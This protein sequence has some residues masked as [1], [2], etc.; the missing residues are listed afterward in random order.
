MVLTNH[1]PYDSDSLDDER[2]PWEMIGCDETETMPLATS[3]IPT[4]VPDAD[5]DAGNQTASN[6]EHESQL[7][8]DEDDMNENNEKEDDNEDGNVSCV[9]GVSSITGDHHSV[10]DVEEEE[11]DFDAAQNNNQGDTPNERQQAPDIATPIDS[12]EKTDAEKSEDHSDP[13]VE[14][15]SLMGFDKELIEK[16]IGDLRAAG[17][18]EIDADS[19]IGSMVGDDTN[20]NPTNLF[21]APISSTWDFVESS[22]QDLDNQHQLRRRTQ[23]C[24]QTIG[25]SA[26]ELWSNVK[27]ESQRFRSNLRETCDQADVQARNTTT[28]ARYAASSARESFCRANEEHRISEKL[29][30]VAVIGGATLLALGN[31]RAGV[32]AMAMAGATLAAGEAMKHSST[33]SS[34]TYTR[35]YGLDEGVHLD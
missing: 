12:P 8:A 13:L 19:V 26:Q 34:S 27:D 5:D 18:T 35:D 32:S 7:K 14:Q 17:A 3:Q 24:A 30:A 31:P 16:A 20:N 4:I 1:K 22:V 21:Q 6:V 25:R 33:Q 29:A 11:E 10:S 15:L 23:N 2:D 9:S 28:H